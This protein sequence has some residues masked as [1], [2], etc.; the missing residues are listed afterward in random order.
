MIT[1]W[2]LC[3]FCRILKCGFCKKLLLYE[4]NSDQLPTFFHFV[5]TFVLVQQQSNSK[6]TKKGWRNEKKWATGQSC[7]YKEVT[8]Y[9]IYTLG[10]LQ[11]HKTW[12]ETVFIVTREF[13]NYPVRLKL[14]SLKSCQNFLLDSF[15][16]FPQ[17]WLKLSARTQ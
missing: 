9:K 10:V 1:S 6:P 13:Q 5:I 17:F 7:I 16:K 3:F 12:L 11:N 4:C 14:F 15:S 2:N 8:S